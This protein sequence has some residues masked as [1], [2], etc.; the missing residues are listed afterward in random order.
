ME[1][2]LVELLVALLAPHR[3]EDVAADKL[4]NNFAVSRQALQMMNIIEFM[5][6]IKYRVSQKNVL[7]WKNGHNYFKTHA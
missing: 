3:E 1:E 6:S 7:L 2:L 4:V 5:L